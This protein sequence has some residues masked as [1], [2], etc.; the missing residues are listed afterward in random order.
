VPKA[1]E[2]YDI[3]ISL[4][5]DDVWN[6]Q[7]NRANAYSDNGN[8]EE[9]LHS[10]DRAAQL[11]TDHG[12]IHYNRGIVFEWL[13]DM[14]RAREE[15]LSAFDAGLRSERLAKRIIVHGLYDKVADR[16]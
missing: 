1:I 16:W 2:A 11:T 12:E 10:Y 4:D 14:P 3:A 9:A 5:P 8:Y 6:D 13:D 15:F 7:V